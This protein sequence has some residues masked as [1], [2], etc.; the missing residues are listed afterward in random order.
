MSYLKQNNYFYKDIIVR[1]DLEEVIPQVESKANEKINE[2]SLSL[3]DLIRNSD[4]SIPIVLENMPGFEEGN[5]LDLYRALITN[6]DASIP[7]VLENMPELEEDNPQDLFRSPA[8]E[9]CLISVS[10]QSLI[11]NECISI[12]P[13]EGRQPKSILNDKFCEELSFP[14]LFPAGNYGY[15]VQREKA[16]S[17][18]KYFNQ[19]LLNYTQK[20]ASDTDYTFLPGMFYKIKICWN[21]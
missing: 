15:Q 8:K 20:F 6:I 11:D 7:I 17:A 12:A 16:L 21:K 1:N 14:H 4:A 5:P 3:L 9:T 19:R 13:G 2:D 10:P 18:V